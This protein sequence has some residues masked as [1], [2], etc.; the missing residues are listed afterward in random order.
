MTKLSA[1]VDMI[2]R[3]HLE[4]FH[5][6]RLLL[7]IKLIRSDPEFCLLTGEGEFI[8]SQEHASLCFR[9]VRFSPRV[10]LEHAKS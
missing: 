10:V 2:D 5:L 7:N 8:I 6:E 9:K 3:L 1:S 4:M